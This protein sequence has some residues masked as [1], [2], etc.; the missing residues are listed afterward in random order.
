MCETD[1]DD[2]EEVET[3]DPFTMRAFVEEL[4]MRLDRLRGKKEI[5]EGERAEFMAFLDSV[6]DTYPNLLS[7]V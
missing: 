3:I 6:E 5:S 1:F 7:Q 4:K 2:L